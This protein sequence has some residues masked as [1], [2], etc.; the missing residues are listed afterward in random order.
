VQIKPPKKA[1]SQPL[2]GRLQSAEPSAISRLLV[3]EA[4]FSLPRCGRSSVV[5]HNLAKVGVE[6]SNLFAR[7][8]P[9][10]FLEEW[11]DDHLANGRA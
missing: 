9:P 4:F 5:E 10:G 7:S 6:S 8:I 1:A 3:A 2:K 11:D